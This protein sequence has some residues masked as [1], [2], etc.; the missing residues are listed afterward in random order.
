MEKF[1]VLGLDTSNYTTSCAVLTE[2]GLDQERRL[3][4]V[5]TGQ[6]GLRQS[7]AVY[8]HIMALPEVSERLLKTYA[9]FTA[10]GV[11]DRPRDQEDS[12][13]PC[14]AVG[15]SM[16]RL[17]AA[18]MRAPLYRF[19]H[20]AGH[21]AAVLYSAGC[22]ELL[23]ERF[24]AFHVS[25]GTTEAILVEPDEEK[26]LKTKIVAASTD[27]KAGQAIDRCA[28]MLGLPFPGGPMLEKLAAGYEGE[29]SYKPSMQGA[30]CSLSGIEN[31][32]KKMLEEGEPQEKIAA[33]CI[34]AVCRSL[35][36]MCQA[37]RGQYGD[38]PVV[39]G[40]GVSSNKKIR[41]FFT[42]QYGARFGEPALSSDN[43]AGIAVLASIAARKGLTSWKE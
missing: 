36:G 38:L 40:G 19:S 18:S 7:D 33:F 42:E 2:E 35:D 23:N 22:L 9:P 26:L 3:L 17:L 32:C 29:L 16:A 1:C 37:L 13:M 12:Y 6:L 28:V 24:L 15:K 39:F 43:A 41:A 20:Q 8:H 21:V 31:K 25:G 11:S 34:E 27:L 5:K 30:N 14:F 4:P 10:I